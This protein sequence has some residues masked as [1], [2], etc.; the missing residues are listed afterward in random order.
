VLRI[1]AGPNGPTRFQRPTNLDRQRV[2]RNVYLCQALCLRIE[3]E[4][5]EKWLIISS[6]GRRLK[7]QSRAREVPLNGERVER[8]LAAILPADVAGH[9]RLMGQDEAGTLV[10]LKAL[11]GTLIYPKIAEHK[12]DI[13]HA[14]HIN[15]RKS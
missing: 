4:L 10:R 1:A 2:D 6:R 14:S 8:R 7:I 12:G 13:C 11:R 15:G 3:A 9:S 5:V